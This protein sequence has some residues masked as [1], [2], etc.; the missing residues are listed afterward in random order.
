[1]RPDQ[2]LIPSRLPSRGR[3]FSAFS[4][5]RSPSFPDLRPARRGPHAGATASKS[6]FTVSVTSVASSA[7]L[8]FIRLIFEDLLALHE[9][10]PP[11][12]TRP[13]RVQVFSTCKTARRCWA[14]PGSTSWRCSAGLR[15]LSEHLLQLVGLLEAAPRVQLL[16]SMNFHGS[17]LIV[18]RRFRGKRSRPLT[19]RI[20]SRFPTRSAG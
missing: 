17:F 18:G 4:R 9:S 20:V 13:R 11:E 6:R 8:S 7:G 16:V 14:R 1:M 10:T 12:A 15:S 3:R 5:R 2:A 19:Q